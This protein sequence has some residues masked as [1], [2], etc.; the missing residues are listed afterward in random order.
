[1]TNTLPD[2]PAEAVLPSGAART[3]ALRA[4]ARDVHTF[5]VGPRTATVAA[6]LAPGLSPAGL[7]DGLLRLGVELYREDHGLAPA[8]AQAATFQL[9][10]GGTGGTR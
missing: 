4:L 9:L 8:D 2:V 1:M 3:A 5:G 7:C 6:G 10:H